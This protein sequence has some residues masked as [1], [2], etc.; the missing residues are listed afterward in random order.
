M[1]TKH[2][3]IVVGAGP[4]GLSVANVMSKQGHEVVVLNRDIKVGGLAE[5]G[6]FPNKH[7]LRGGLRKGYWEILTRPNVRYFGN[8]TVGNGYHLTVSELRALGPSALVFSTGAQGT[9]TI[10]VE[11]DTAKGVYHAKDCVYHYNLLPGFST[12]P[13]EM[14][15]RVAVIGIG[16]VMVD[17]AH[18]LSRRR[19]VA[20]VH[21]IVRRG[22]AERKYNPKE[23]RAVCASI[24]QDSLQK[25]IARIAPRLEAVG[26]LPEKILAEMRAEFTKCEPPESHTRMHFHFLSS[27]KRVLTDGQNQ[28]IGLEVE[29]TKLELKGTDPA[30][31][32]LKTYYTIP[33]DSVVFAVGDRVDEAVGL[34]YKNGVF[35]TNPNRTQNDPDDSLFQAYD[36]TTGAVI[37]EVFLCGWARKASDGLVGVA[38]RDGEWCSEVVLRHLADKAPLTAEEIAHKL[39]RLESLVKSRQPD[40]VQVDDLLALNEMEQEEGQRRDIEEFKFP[41]NEEML[42][43]IRRKKSMA[44]VSASR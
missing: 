23:I 8:V 20:E 24:D 38:K 14:G 28:V 11:G 36:E 33:C 34:P 37:P 21:V 12:R 10:G 4:A 29:D 44:K 43:A 18:W 32:W 30:A 2:L 1:S 17:I 5:Y 9:K 6:I 7:K 35:V 40:V 39:K 42:V 15:Q 19:R 16:D 22:P 3:I 41:T 13:F 26:Q 27:P 31:V 25:E